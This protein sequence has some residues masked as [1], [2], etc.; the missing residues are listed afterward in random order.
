LAWLG[1]VDIYG[2]LQRTERNNGFIYEYWISNNEYKEVRN[3]GDYVIFPLTN[4]HSVYN[5]SKT[6]KISFSI[7]FKI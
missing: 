1:D 3:K 2:K 7:S 6:P 4:M 5:F